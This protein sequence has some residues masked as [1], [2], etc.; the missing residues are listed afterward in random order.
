M[1]LTIF[2]GTFLTFNLNDGMFHKIL[3]VVE[4]V[5]MDLN[6]VMSFQVLDFIVNFAKGRFPP[7]P[8]S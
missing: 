1:G 2:G 5:V 7:N 8:Y 4:N 3:S 6:D